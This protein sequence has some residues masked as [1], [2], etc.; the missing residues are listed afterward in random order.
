MILQ[1]NILSDLAICTIK[2]N[3]VMS[4]GEKANINRVI[5]FEQMWG[6]TALGFNGIGGD[7][8]TSAWTH[9]V[10]TEEGRYFVFF[11]GRLAY[12]VENPTDEFIDDLA[13]NDMKSV[14]EALTK[15]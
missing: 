15:Y 5:V 11:D 12:C 13:K 10:I 6:N 3:D 14:R 8:M 9:V 1:D 2:V 4:R 7:S